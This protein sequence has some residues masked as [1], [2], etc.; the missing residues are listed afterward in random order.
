[1]T[2]RTTDLVSKVEPREGYTWI[3]LEGTITENADLSAILPETPQRVVL[4]LSGIRRINSSGVLLWIAFMRDLERHGAEVTLDRC[5][6]SVVG[7]LNSI[8][9]FKGGG[10]V[11]SVL[12]PY[13][14]DNC[15]EDHNVQIPAEPASVA[16]L[17]EPHPCPKCGSPMEFD[18]LPDNFLS[19]VTSG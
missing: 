4:D 2:T 12:A 14:C 9:G 15:D 3:A 19:F 16:T 7:Q 10:S 11:R 17:T 1:M 5:S 13:H 8:T 6:A 18:D